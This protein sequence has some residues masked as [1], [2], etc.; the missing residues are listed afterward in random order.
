M[1]KYIEVKMDDLK[2]ISQIPE[3]E[4]VP[5]EA[6][7]REVGYKAIV[8]K[9]NMNSI[10]VVPNKNQIIQHQHVWEEVMKLKDYVIRK[11]EL[12]KSGQ[13]LMIEVT[14]REPRKIELLP[15]DHIE[16][17]ARI[18]NDYSKSR[19]LEVA[20]YATRLVCTNGMVGPRVGRK[21]QIHAYG[22]AE[23]NEEME[24]QINACL[25]VWEDPKVKDI[26]EE[27]ADTT[28]NVKDILSDYSL[29]PKKYMEKVVEK[30]GNEE[31]VYE[32]WNA[33]TYVIQHDMSDNIQT[34][35]RINL[36]KRANKVLEIPKL[37]VKPKEV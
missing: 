19:G 18:F 23:F 34:H 29:L 13:R 7:D 21:M 30:L 5:L 4:E 8:D 20:V 6:H 33:F 35:G 3:V 9:S 37:L 16:C 2:K 25:E 1:A 11:V 32:I 31:T 26:F 36:Q 14:E 10:C 22:T 15:K 24:Q 12:L 28:V 17:G 27:A